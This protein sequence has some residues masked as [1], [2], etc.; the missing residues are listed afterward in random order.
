MGVENRRIFSIV[1]KRGDLRPDQVRGAKALEDVK[2]DAINA[3][4]D[5]RF[6]T[7]PDAERDAY[8]VHPNL[9]TRIAK[10]IRGH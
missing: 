7:M 4:E 5:S 6:D 3:K 9:R 1:F 10:V 8:Y 2:I